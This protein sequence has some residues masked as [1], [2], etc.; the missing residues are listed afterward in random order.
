MKAPNG[1]DIMGTKEITPGAADITFDGTNWEHSG[2]GTKVYWDYQITETLVDAA[3]FVDESGDE[4]CEHHLIPDDVPHLPCAT[5]DLIM[6][7]MRMARA[8]AS[9]GDYIL[10]LEAMQRGGST[11]ILDMAECTADIIVT[12][13]EEYIVARACLEEMRKKVKNEIFLAVGALKENAA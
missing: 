9:L 1:V 13:S 3:V 12:H 2:N 11:I 8:V 4:W 6:E 7:E 5:V 10:A